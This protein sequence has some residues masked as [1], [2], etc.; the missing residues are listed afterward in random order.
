MGKIYERCFKKEVDKEAV[1]ILSRCDS[2]NQGSWDET[3]RIFGTLGYSSNLIR[4]I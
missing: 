3:Y 4:E 2:N 1:S